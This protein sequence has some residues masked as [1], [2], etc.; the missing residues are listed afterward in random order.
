MFE[1]LRAWLANVAAEA[2]TENPDDGDNSQENSESQ[3]AE[4]LLSP[5][6]YLNPSDLGYQGGSNVWDEFFGLKSIS[7]PAIMNIRGGTLYLKILAALLAAKRTNH[8]LYFAGLDAGA[9]SYRYGRCLDLLFRAAEEGMYPVLLLSNNRYFD[10][11][12][13]RKLTTLKESLRRACVR[14]LL[15]RDEDR[16]DDKKCDGSNDRTAACARL[17]TRQERWQLLFN[18]LGGADPGILS[19]RLCDRLAAQFHDQGEAAIFA[20]SMENM[21]NLSRKELIETALQSL[22]EC[23]GKKDPLEIALALSKLVLKDSCKCGDGV[24]ADDFIVNKELDVEDLVRKLSQPVSVKKPRRG[25]KSQTADEN[26]DPFGPDADANDDYDPDDPWADEPE[27]ADPD[28]DDESDD[29][30]DEE[31]SD[32][33]DE[34]E[35]SDDD[36]NSEEQ[37]DDSV[38]T[39]RKAPGTVLTVKDFKNSTEDGDMFDL[40]FVCSQD[41]PL[42]FIDRLSRISKKLEEGRNV[43]AHSGAVLFY[44]PPGTGKT[45]LA[46]HIGALIGR[47]VRVVTAADLLRRYMGETEQLIKKTFENA[48]KKGELLVIDEVDYLLHE[49]TDMSQAF[50]SSMVNQFL[51][52]MNTYQ[53]LLICT[54]NCFDAL[55]DAVQ[56]R[57]TQKFRFDYAK[58][59]QLKPMWNKY[60]GGC[61]TRELTEQEEQRLTGAKYLTPGDFL[62]VRN[63]FDPDLGYPAQDPEVLLKELEKQMLAK[64]IVSK[65]VTVTTRRIGFI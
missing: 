43:G 22:E 58:P 5:E 55:D 62:N 19:E 51:T 56:R 60:L 39:M 17:M 33:E 26:E 50:E 61:A 8:T 3:S 63:I 41:D 37:E 6:I 59:H 64:K 35:D 48:S 38:R 16:P 54:T 14:M 20:V 11:D 32:S 23:L 13:Q 27:S 12:I 9:D 28:E 49:R 65:A 52:S 57:F 24:L 44:G 4:E 42:Q 46:T 34:D 53:G 30:E 29:D 7:F 31:Q 1:S 15:I 40:S 45:E 10:Y 36:E 18:I 25:K 2:E 47:K 21:E